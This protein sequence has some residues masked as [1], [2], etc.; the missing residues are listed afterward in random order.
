MTTSGI[1]F[2]TVFDVVIR[3]CRRVNTCQVIQA[4]T[5]SNRKKERRVLKRLN[6]AR[7][8][9]RVAALRAPISPQHPTKT[10]LVASD[11]FAFDERGQ[12]CDLIDRPLLP[13]H[14][15]S[16]RTGEICEIRESVGPCGWCERWAGSRRAIKRGLRTLA[17]RSLARLSSVPPQRLCLSVVRWLP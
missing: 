16:T 5:Q 3:R 15:E 4:Q 13:T 9:L 11:P 8:N 10:L 1:M 14:A 7:R 6:L 17:G 12:I 2:N